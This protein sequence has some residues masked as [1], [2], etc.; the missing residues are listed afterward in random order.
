MIASDG[1]A[2]NHE[3]LKI[4]P[5]AAYVRDTWGMP[6]S[7]RWLAKLAVVGGGP[8]YSK[9]GRT[10]LYT[11]NDLDEWAKQRIGARRCP[12]SVLVDEPLQEA[13]QRAAAASAA[14]VELARRMAPDATSSV[15]AA[16]QKPSCPRPPPKT[17]GKNRP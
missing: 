16:R 7:P 12:T 4:T 8:I 13:P 5:A 10:P 15:R 9:A 6:C 2:V 17:C 3:F 14:K 1:F 11:T